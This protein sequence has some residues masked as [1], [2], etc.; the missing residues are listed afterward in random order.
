[1]ELDE[2]TDMKVFSA[3]TLAKIAE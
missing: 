1:M 3:S 2:N